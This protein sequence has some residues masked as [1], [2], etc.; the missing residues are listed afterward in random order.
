M[1]M[2]VLRRLRNFSLTVEKVGK[3]DVFRVYGRLSSTPAFES[4]DYGETVERLTEL[5]E[6]VTTLTP[7][8]G[9]QSICLCKDGNFEVIRT[10]G[11]LG[12]ELVWVY[13]LK[14][15]RN[16]KIVDRSRNY[17]VIRQMMHECAKREVTA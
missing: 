5:Q 12:T 8:E 1:K 4:K 2:I 17:D 6:A 14:D 9:F 15:I 3:S 11:R 13:I 10:T 7:P 16:G